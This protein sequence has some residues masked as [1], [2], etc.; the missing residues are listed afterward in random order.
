[1]NVLLQVDDGE[2]VLVE[3][4]LVLHLLCHHSEEVDDDDVQCYTRDD[5][6]EEDGDVPTCP[7][8]PAPPGPD[9]DAVHLVELHPPARLPDCTIPFQTHLTHD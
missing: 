2:H 5:V 7:T 4:L 8:S 1:M 3:Q 6:K 9:Q